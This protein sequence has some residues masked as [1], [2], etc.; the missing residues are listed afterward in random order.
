MTTFNVAGDGGFGRSND[1]S[2]SVV[3]D[4]IKAASFR[5]QLFICFSH[6]KTQSSVL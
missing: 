4:S 6:S 2:T 5:F 3:C 1:V